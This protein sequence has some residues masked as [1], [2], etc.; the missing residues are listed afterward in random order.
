MATRLSSLL[1]PERIILSL[2]STK[3]TAALQETAKLL[4][5]DPN[6]ANFQGFYNELLARERLDTTCLGNEVALPHARTEHVK[7]IV[8]AV[9]RSTQGVL[10]ENS[11]QN[12]KLMFV[13]GT[14]KNN[15]TDYLILVGALCRLIKDE[16]SRTALLAA[17]TP[18]AFIATVLD[19]E[20]K[21]LGPAK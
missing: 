16:S 17:P 15:P 14:P 2:Q 21:I 5:A 8:L 9:G 7:K 6:V 20:S 10:F 1:S 4:E 19:L 13:L 3:R 11:N 12:V 18:E